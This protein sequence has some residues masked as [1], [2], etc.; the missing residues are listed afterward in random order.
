MEYNTTYT[1][2]VYDG[3]YIYA[4]DCIRHR[5]CFQYCT[6]MYINKKIKNKKEDEKYPYV[7]IY[8]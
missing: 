7:I 6:Y 1:Y 3:I 2:M 4:H 5:V 8:V